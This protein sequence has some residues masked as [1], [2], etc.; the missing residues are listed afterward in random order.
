MRNGLFSA[1]I[2]A[3]AGA[4]RLASQSDERAQ[5]SSRG[6]DAR[7][8]E[9]FRAVEFFMARS[10]SWTSELQ[11]AHWLDWLMALDRSETGKVL[12][13]AAIDQRSPKV[14]RELT[15]ATWMKSTGRVF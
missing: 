14:Q 4:E 3:S 2:V 11:T 9:T 1:C 5:A 7:D 10:A 13:D 6:D 12:P 8:D 15:R